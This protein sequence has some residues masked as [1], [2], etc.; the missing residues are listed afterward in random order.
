MTLPSLDQIKEIRERLG[1]PIFEGPYNLNITGFRSENSVS[2]SYDDWMT[3]VYQNDSKV[4]QRFYARCTTDPGKHWLLNPMN[5][6]GT[7]ILIPDHYPGMYKVGRHKTYEALE[8]QKPG[9][10]VRDNDKNSVLDFSLYRDPKKRKKHVFEGNIKANI[11][12]SS[13][14]KRTMNVGMYS[15]GC[16]VLQDPNEFLEFMDLCKRG[17]KMY[18][19]SLSYT[20]IEEIEMK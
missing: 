11:H 5:A 19:N 1:Y 14:W 8:Q 4:W 18:G 7:A 15:A 20:L 12:R 13:K 2:N 9:L 17:T 6:K 16:Q 10:Y 3:V